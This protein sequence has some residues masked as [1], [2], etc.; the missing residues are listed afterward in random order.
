MYRL[1]RAAVREEKPGQPDKDK[2][3][4]AECCF[5]WRVIGREETLA[6][7]ARGLK[8]GVIDTDIDEAHPAFAGRTIH[9]FDFSPDGHGASNWHGTAVLSLLAG[10]PL[11]ARPVLSPT[12][13][14]S[15]P[16]SFF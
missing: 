13:N 14:S 1:Y 6:P 10:S 5:A 8:V 4:A 7:C 2:P 11:A 15:P 9:R 16:T 12:R 3:T